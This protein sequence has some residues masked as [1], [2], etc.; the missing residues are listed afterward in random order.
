[1]R[2]KSTLWSLAAVLILTTFA[3]AVSAATTLRYS[4]YG[5]NRGTRAKALEWFADQIKERSGG[6]LV[7]EFHW[8]GSLLGGKAT[9]KGVGD[10]VADMGTAIGFFTPKKL[11]AYNMGDLPVDNSDPWV[12]MRAFYDIASGHPALQKEFADAGVTYVTN[13]TTGPIQLICKPEVKTLADLK[14]KK[15]RGSGPYGKAFS[16]LGAIVQR[17]SQSKVYQALDSGLVECNQ[18]YYYSMKAYKQYEVAGNVLALD[19]GQN[20][21]FGVV[22]NK[23]VLDGLS[24]KLQAVISDASSDFIDHLGRAM[25]EQSNGD[26]MAM[27]KGIDGKS[28]SISRLPDTERERLLDAGRKYIKVWEEETNAAGK[29]GTGLL[30]AYV[31]RVEHYAAERAAKGYPWAR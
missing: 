27:E 11:K 25:I 13:F 9:L 29:D 10:G 18:N 6:E 3:T 19:W 4:D 14:G 8:G 28:I 12:G 23:A 31:A 20:M 1:M 5:P 17:M 30:K 26:K 22:M 16:D 21:S 24:A 15:L 7:V 2:I